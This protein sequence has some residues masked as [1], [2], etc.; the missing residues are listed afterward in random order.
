MVK[1]LL[2]KWLRKLV[3]VD[4]MQFGFM[5]GKSTVDAIFIFRRVHEIYLEKNR[6]IYS[7]S[8]DLEKTFDWVPKKVIEWALRKKLVLERLFQAVMSM[9]KKAKTRVQAG[10]EHW[11]EFD[12]GVGVHQES[13][14]SPFLS[15]VLDILSEDGR[16]GALYELFYA[17]YLVLIAET[18]E[19]LETQFIGWK[20]AFEEKKLKVNFGET[21]VIESGGGSGLLS[22][23]IY[24]VCGKRPKV[25]CVRCK[26]C[27]KSTHARCARIKKVSCKM[28]GNFDAGF[29]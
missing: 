22:W 25:N 14:F 18:M 9:Y 6:K 12:A 21:K 17:G 5:P 8:V 19:E 24:V 2:E 1:R 4:Q 16:K 7:C 23:L 11:E 29:L 20:A 13:V 26:T 10:G 3:K 28:N 27:K 15:I